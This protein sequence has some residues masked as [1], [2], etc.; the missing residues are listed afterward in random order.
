MVSFRIQDDQVTCAPPPAEEGLPGL[1]V[2]LCER[3]G[4]ALGSTATAGG[5]IFEGN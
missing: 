5:R 4:M 3:D 1:R 2:A